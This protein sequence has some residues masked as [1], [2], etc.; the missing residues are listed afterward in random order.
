[1]NDSELQEL[2][3]GL[4]MNKINSFSHI[5]NGY[6]GSKSFLLK[7]GEVVKTLKA[8]NPGKDLFYRKR[9]RAKLRKK[10]KMSKNKNKEKITKGKIRPKK[11]CPLFS[12]L[13][14]E[15]LVNIDFNILCILV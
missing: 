6:I 12:N 7:L 13:M 2:M 10:M 9:K 3:D 5:I 8:V 11:K 4:Q 15:I 14:Y 1:M